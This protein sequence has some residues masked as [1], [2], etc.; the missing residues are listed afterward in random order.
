[1]VRGNRF[2]HSQAWRPMLRGGWIDG[3]GW[4]K[5][6]RTNKP[7]KVWRYLEYGAVRRFS[8]LRPERGCLGRDVQP[9]KSV[10][11]AGWERHSCAGDRVWRLGVVRPASKTVV[12]PYSKYVEPGAVR[13]FSFLRKGAASVA[14]DV[15]PRTAVFVAGWWTAL[16]CVGPGWEAGGRASRTLNGGRTVRPIPSPRFDTPG[17][18]TILAD[19]R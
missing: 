16:V 15:Q 5:K 4:V 14:K 11:V 2:G 9:E 1:M 6:A 19:L 12:A 10:F 13:R 17:G 3:G 7:K 8:F 18:V